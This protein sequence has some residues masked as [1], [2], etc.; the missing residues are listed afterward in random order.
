MIEGYLGGSGES[1]QQ[2]IGFLRGL[3]YCCR[4]VAWQ[5]RELM[6][7]IDNLIKS[8]DEQEFMQALPEMRLSFADLTPRETDRVAELVSGFYE[9]QALGELVN[10]DIDEA[11]LHY[12]LELDKI[13]R[14]SLRQDQ[15]QTLFG[16]EG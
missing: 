15:L 12:G 6:R 1:W 14:E 2:K 16:I 13:V 9:G 8:W 11:T 4:E 7:S 5:N 10:R 3:L